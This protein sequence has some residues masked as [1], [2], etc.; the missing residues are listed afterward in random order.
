[1]PCAHVHGAAGLTRRARPRWEVAD[2]FRLHGE[3]YRRSQPLPLLHLKIMR[4]IAACRTVVLGGHRERCDCCGFERPAYNSCLN[5][6][7]PKCQVLAKAKWLEARSAELLPVGYFH[8][9]FTLPHV[10]NLLIL[11]NKAVVLKILF[12][13]VAQTLTQFGHNPRNGL[14]GKL[15]FLAVLHTWDQ[16]LLDH[17]HLHCL[18]PAGVLSEDGLRWIHARKDF[19]F[20]VKAL[21]EVFRGKFVALLKQAFAQKQLTFPGRAASTGHPAGFSALMAELYRQGWVVYCKP[22]F[23]GPHKVLDYLGRYTHRVAIANHRIQTVADGNV[24]FSYRDRR[25]HDTTKSLTVP[26]EEFIRRFLLH[27]LPPSFMRIR[28]FGFLANRCKGR[29]LPRC[30]ELLGLPPEIPEPPPMTN[31]ERLRGLTGDNPKRCPACK[32]GKMLVVAELPK[33]PICAWPL[34]PLPSLRFDSS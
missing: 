32:V 4:A 6:H 13:A 17:F 25:D 19:L 33:L 21:A 22:P 24:T 9:V 1:M 11:C 14:G 18:I 23:G 29:D 7:C 2:V 10:L 26:A 31:E 8:V 12:D 3:A 34:F 20:P 5:R 15:G 30:R 16:K 27:A 28:H